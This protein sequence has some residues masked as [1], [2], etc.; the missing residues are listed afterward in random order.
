MLT[1]TAAAGLRKGLDIGV[2]EI[3]GR[4]ADFGGPDT[5]DFNWG[6]LLLPM[7]GGLL[8]GLLVR[9]LC[10]RS[11]GHGT[12]QYI[13]AFHQHR[14][15]LEFRGPAVKAV[16]AIGVISF[17]GSAGPEAPIA[18]LGA[19]IGSRVAQ[20][21]KLSPREMRVMLVAGCGGGVGAVFQCPLGGALFAASVLYREPEFDA[22][23]MVPAFVS[24]VLSYST[25][26]TLLGTGQHMLAGA[27]SLVFTHPRELPAYA[28]LGPLCGV[29]SILLFKS[30]RA[31]E[32]IGRRTS[33]PGW[34]RPAAGGLMVGALGCML[35][36]VMDGQ[37][38][39]I[40]NAMNGT[41]FTAG[42]GV[43]GSWWPVALFG[44]VAVFK[45]IATALTVG[46]GA[47]GGALG[48]SVWIGGAA[49]A[50]LG[51]FLQAAFPN[52]LPPEQMDAL[53]RSLIPV[54][55]AGVIAAGMRTP[56][57][58]VV[59]VT[60]MTG[61]YGLIVPL[62]L[63]CVTAYVTGRRWGLNESQ[64]ARASE[65]P[66]HAGDLLVNSLESVAVDQVMDHHWP[67]VVEP[68]ATLG[69]IVARAGSDSRP[70]FAVVNGQQLLGIISL[71]DI[72]R[73]VSEPGIAE[74]VIASDIM[75]EQVTTAQPHQ[76]LYDIM[77]VFR[78]TRYEVLPVIAD[79]SEGRWLGMLRR[80]AIHEGLRARVSELRRH[81]HRE[82][83][84]FAGIEQD[85]QLFELVL[86]VNPVRPGTIRR[87]PVPAQVIGQT[88]R[89]AAFS[90]T[91]GAQVIGVQDQDGTMHC[92]PQLDA[93]LRSDQL[94][95]VIAAE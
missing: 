25:F 80:Q 2:R 68:A 8:S 7:A 9:L 5:F 13:A 58:A 85:E 95:I 41:L 92:P 22:D 82:H 60:E 83:A 16:G 77:D 93:P 38:H 34:L 50:F 49:G 10:P 30:F 47:S 91:F 67:Y 44:A 1:G 3:I 12:D 51:A 64:V 39:F 37:Y 20:W 6:I 56:M 4:F 90:T 19:A 55:M 76:S 63:V 43:V 46:S 53:C 73:A 15:Q 70:T 79:G 17:G 23:S 71:S 48:P 84:G 33:L 27:G 52:S 54:G 87:I 86:G 66:A 57:A 29:L 21:M 40:Q 45:C 72:S 61:S 18:A 62:M 35:P 14:G 89:G 31:M 42:G 59:M 26:I 78:G 24:S 65:S 11:T 32:A 81:L 75:T 69:E 28:V 94:L 36:Q 74:L 88:I